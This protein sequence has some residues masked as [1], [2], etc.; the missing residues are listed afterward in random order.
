MPNLSPDLFWSGEPHPA[1][2]MAPDPKSEL[3]ISSSPYPSLFGA[4]R[5]GGR[6][7][8]S[9]A[10]LWDPSGTCLSPSPPVPLPRSPERGVCPCLLPASRSPAEICLC[11]P[12]LDRGLFLL[13]GAAGRWGRRK[14]G[15]NQ[16]PGA[17]SGCKYL[18]VSGFPVGPLRVPVRSG[19][20][21][22]SPRSLPGSGRRPR[23][24]APGPWAPSFPSSCVFSNL[25]HRMPSPAWLWLRS[26]LRLSLLRPR[27]SAPAQPRTGLGALPVREGM[28]GTGG[29]CSAGAL[30]AWEG[31]R[32]QAVGCRPTGSSGGAR[33]RDAAVVPVPRPRGSGPPRGRSGCGHGRREGTG[34]SPVPALCPA[35]LL[36]WRSLQCMSA[37]LSGHDCQPR[38]LGTPCLGHCRAGALRGRWRQGSPARAAR[39]PDAS[40]CWGEPPAAEVRAV[41]GHRAWPS[42][43]LRWPRLPLL[44]APGSPAASSWLTGWGWTAA[45]Q[46]LTQPHTAVPSGLLCPARGAARRGHSVP[47]CCAGWRARLATRL[48][49]CPV[50]G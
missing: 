17:G 16:G 4:W 1:A 32:G 11:F 49:R 5:P 12:A 18:A 35:M 6:F 48:R 42:L 2:V 40:P 38:T 20:C 29:V 10:F 23:P 26:V 14:Q 19:R 45:T 43:L 28:E 31:D 44:A 13:V 30:R 9:P 15:G 33:V 34:G 25:A 47:V 50:P 27:A 46:L 24:A 8:L 3:P 39:C 7:C 37:P 41:L 36:L 21:G 22:A